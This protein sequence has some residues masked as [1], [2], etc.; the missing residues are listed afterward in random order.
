VLPFDCRERRRH[1]FVEASANLRSSLFF[2]N[3]ARRAKDV[4]LTSS[5]PGEGKSLASANLA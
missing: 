1:S 4:L 3:A 2:L 5:V